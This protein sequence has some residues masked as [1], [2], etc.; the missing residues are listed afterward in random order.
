MIL[1]RENT[2]LRI[3][4]FHD[5]T[6]GQKQKT[7]WWNIIAD[8]ANSSW[9]RGFGVREGIESMSLWLHFDSTSMALLAL[10]SL[11]S[12]YGFTPIPLRWHFDSTSSSLRICSD[13]PSI[14]L[15]FHFGFTSMFFLWFHI[16]FTAISLRPH[17]GCTS[18]SLRSHFNINLTKTPLGSLQIQFNIVSISL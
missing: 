13:L 2:N 10:L 6:I 7:S 14:S 11:W 18:M 15:R 17:F 4:R 8:K 5:M 3:P 16:E 9:I 12:H 1:V